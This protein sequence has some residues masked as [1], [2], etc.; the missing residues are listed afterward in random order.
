MKLS[1]D[2]SSEEIISRGNT[3]ML[4]SERRAA[5]SLALIYS[6]RMFGLFIILPVFSLYASE[7]SSSTPLLIGLALGIYGLFQAILQIPFGFLSDRLGRKPVIVGGFLLFALGSVI[8]ALSSDIFGLIIGRALQGAGAVASAIMALA[9]DLSREEQRT[10]MMASLGASIGAAFVFSLVM[11]PVLVNWLDLSGLFWLTFV[12]A[13]LGIVILLT[14]VPTPVQA[15]A[16]GD[17]RP[18]LQRM[19]QLLTDPQLLRLDLGIFFLHMMVSATFFAV[20]LTLV[21]AGLPGEGHWKIYL[22]ALALSIAV[23]IPL[24]LAAERHG[25]FRKVFLICILGLLFSQFVFWTGMG[26][27]STT[28]LFVGIAI[29]FSFFNTM[30]AM[31][32]SLVSKLAPVDGKGSAMGVYSSSQFLGAFFGGVTGGW[33]YSFAGAGGLYIALAL[34]CAL[35]WLIALGMT[36]PHGFATHLVRVGSIGQQEASRLAEKFTALSGVREAVVVAD[37]GVAYLRV[38]KLKFDRESLKKVSLSM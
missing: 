8:A 10:K 6:I 32:P 22:P 17:T 18:T 20:P 30:E 28:A 31:L 29:F 34:I 12:A 2:P 23:M 5:G 3:R 7:Y 37:E 26:A 24:I 16:G 21:E 9:A 15:R 14:L 11:G 38:D 13:L 4:P 19:Q 36:N 33:V 25:H 35:W 1:S 27:L